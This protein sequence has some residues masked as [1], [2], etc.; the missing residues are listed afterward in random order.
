MARRTG[1]VMVLA[2]VGALALGLL[3]SVGAADRGKG[4]SKRSFEVK[5]IGYEEVPSIS[6]TGKGKLKLKINNGST[7]TI[8][9][10]LSYSGLT[11]PAVMSHIHFAQKG[12]NGAIVL[13]LCESATNPD[14]DPAADTPTCPAG[15]T[16]TRE[17]VSGTLAATD[18]K[19][20]P[21]GIAAGELLEVLAAMKFGV[22]YANV[23]TS[24]TATPP[25]FIGGEIRG[26]L[27]K[28]RHGG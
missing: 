15:N 11:A 1:L 8:D 13:W 28:S 3:A 7:G 21:Q 16:A 18:V 2:I 9:Y 22:T 6:S 14:P 4:K 12:V 23:H 19:G 25:G 10:R 5:L 27:G 17:T 20:T 26:Q 24:P